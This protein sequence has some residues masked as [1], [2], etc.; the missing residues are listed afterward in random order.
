MKR[1]LSI[2]IYLFISSFLFAQEF[3]ILKVNRIEKLWV[4]PPDRRNFIGS[5]GIQKFDY[6]RPIKSENAGEHY[7]VTWR[8]NG[9]EAARHMVFKFEY[10]SALRLDELRDELHVEKCSYKNL[11]RGNYKWIFKNI[12]PR[13]AGEGKV[14]RWKVSLVLDGK[15][16]AEKRSATWHAMEGT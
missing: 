8:Y 4:I 5:R 12:G 14:D 9:R 16:V 13:F 2:L 3:R 6:G 15:I 10:R 11:K 7:V 1:L